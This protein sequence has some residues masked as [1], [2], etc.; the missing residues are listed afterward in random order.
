MG[1]RIQLLVKFI[2]MVMKQCVKVLY[3][4]C[5]FRLRMNEVLI[6]GS[7]GIALQQDSLQH[8]LLQERVTSDIRWPCEKMLTQIYK[9][10]R[11]YWNG[12]I[13]LSWT[14]GYPFLYQFRLR[15]YCIYFSPLVIGNLIYVGEKTLKF[16]Q[17]FL[18]TPS[19]KG[20]Q[21]L[22]VY[23]FRI[24]SMLIPL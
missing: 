17:F 5:F 12:L 2:E 19:K 9:N 1:I 16:K 20:Y 4:N 14:Y 13:I 15:L 18:C 7:I 11:M 22:H 24:L 6:L 8:L 3:F 10:L 23:S 21:I